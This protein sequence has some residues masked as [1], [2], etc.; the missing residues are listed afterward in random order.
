MSA[1]KNLITLRIIWAAFVAMITVAY[2]TVLVVAAA[3]G[4]FEPI[5]VGVFAV[6]ALAETGLLAFF[7]FQAFG[8]TLGIVAP[9]VLREPEEVTGEALEKAVREAFPK[10][11]TTTIV[12]LAIAMSIALYGFVLGFLTA[13]LLYY[14]PF[15]AYALLLIAVQFPR[16]A[17]IGCLLTRAEWKGL[18]HE[19]DANV[20][21]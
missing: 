20:G 18:L 11:Q 21:S 4:D 16:A 17:G 3:P 8:P 15:A 2:P 5:M 1:L 6:I 7:R 13:D 9:E 14:L 12:G 10:Y 19:L